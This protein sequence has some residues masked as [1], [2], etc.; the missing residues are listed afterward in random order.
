M[1][2]LMSGQHAQLLES[3]GVPP[4]ARGSKGMREK[5]RESTAS[6]LVADEVFVAETS[7]LVAQ[8]TK[9]E[10]CSESPLRLSKLPTH[11]R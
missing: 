9:A 2:M 6:R 3:G 10:K 7:G 11:Q 5:E 1:L 8:A 4:V